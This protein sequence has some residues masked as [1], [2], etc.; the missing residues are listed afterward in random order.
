MHWR[1]H[2]DD[3]RFLWARIGEHVRAPFV[4]EAYGRFLSESRDIS[5]RYFAEAHVAYYLRTRGRID[6]GKF[7]RIIADIRSMLTQRQE[8]DHLRETGELLGWTLHEY[9]IALQN[10]AQHLESKLV[11]EE[12]TRQR[13]LIGDSQVSYSIF[14]MFMNGWIAHDRHA[15]S[16]DDFSPPGWRSWLSSVLERYEAV[17][18]EAN[19][20]EHHGTTIHNKAFVLQVLALEHEG[21]ERT[22]DAQ[23]EFTIAKDLYLMA[24]NIRRRLR[25]PR[26]MAQSQVRIC[27][28]TLGLARVA[29]NQ[30]NKS[31]AIALTSEAEQLGKETKEIYKTVPQEDMRLRDVERIETEAARL[32]RECLDENGF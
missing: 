10:S 11:L 17:Y 20:A 26:M 1:V 13:L 15:L 22:E 3:M 32:R 25:D 6:L 5:R 21:A 9:G 28:C 12:A 2:K 31:E 29:C 7:Q 27:E 18:R 4:E 16:V 8:P 14:Q 23:R 19:S 24:Y 30:G